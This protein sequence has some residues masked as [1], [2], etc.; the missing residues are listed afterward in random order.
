[1]TD[2]AIETGFDV[3]VLWARYHDGSGVEILRAFDDEDE[4]K[5]QK[6]MIDRT[7]PGMA[8]HIS[9]VEHII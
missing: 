2:D 1:M 6:A 8:I 7:S 3:W 5:R 9:K 4:A